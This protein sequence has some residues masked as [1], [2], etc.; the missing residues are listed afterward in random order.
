LAPLAAALLPGMNCVLAPGQSL[1]GMPGGMRGG[2]LSLRCR[3]AGP[4]GPEPGAARGGA[5]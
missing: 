2:H 3:R 4:L 5:C 1:C